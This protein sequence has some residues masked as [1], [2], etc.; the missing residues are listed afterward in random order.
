MSVRLVIALVVFHFFSSLSHGQGFAGL[1]LEGNGYAKVEKGKIFAFPQDHG[2][3]PDYRI[4]W[5]YITANLEDSSGKQYGI[6]WTL[7]RQAT[8]PPPQREGWHSQQVWLGHAAVSAE[9]KHLSAETVA[10]GLTG[11]AGVT[12]D[13]LSVWID[14]WNLSSNAKPGDDAL[15]SIEL[16]ASAK[17]FSYKLAMTAEGGLVFHGLSGISK[18]SDLGQSSFYYSQPFYSVAGKLMIE[19]Q[20]VDVA[21]KAWL[22]REWSSQPLSAT[23]TGWDWFSIHLASGEKVMLFRLRNAAADNYYSGT[24]I[25]ADGTT[26]QLDPTAIKFSE[27]EKTEVQNHIIPTRWRLEVPSRQLDIETTPLNQDSWMNTSIQYWEGP[28]SISGSHEG[29]GYLEMTGYDAEK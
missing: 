3:H 26:S 7:F 11:Q 16:Q 17:D 9:G 6:Q 22:D 18:K 8:A 5:W 15:S 21:G 12:T 20:P 2:A 19:G 10:R 24:W 25:S 14:D 23:Q 1:G 13:P 28:I 27:L 29:V 4:E